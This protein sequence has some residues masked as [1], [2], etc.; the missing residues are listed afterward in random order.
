MSRSL[1][2][3]ANYCIVYI[4]AQKLPIFIYIAL[5]KSNDMDRAFFLHYKRE[6]RKISCITIALVCSIVL[7]L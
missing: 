5:R 1:F 2:M 6:N 4:I 7:I 3:I